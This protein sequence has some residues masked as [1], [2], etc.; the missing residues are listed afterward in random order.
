MGQ[1]NI[2]FRPGSLD[3]LIGYTEDEI[4]NI[5]EAV[6]EATTVLI[7]GE[8]GTRKCVTG[9]TLVVTNRGLLPIGE[10]IDT[11]GYTKYKGSLHVR[12]HTGEWEKPSHVLKEKSR[13][14][15]VET[16]RGNTIKAT[17]EHP[18]LV[19]NSNGDIGWVAV[20]SI[21]VGGFLALGKGLDSDIE[22]YVEIDNS[23]IRKVMDFNSVEYKLPDVVTE[24]VATILGLLV[25]EGSLANGGKNYVA[26]TNTDKNLLKLFKRILHAWDS[27]FKFDTRISHNGCPTVRVNSSHLKQYLESAGLIFQHCRHVEIPRAI[28]CS[29]KTVQR[30]FLRAYFEGDG[31]LTVQDGIETITAMN[32]F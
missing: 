16:D 11:I 13:V 14:I 20:D 32:V 8:T 5:S 24:D 23:I 19:V 22:D 10:C 25:S 21:K 12:T 28:M 15:L 6:A 3:K 27:E 17:P 1:Y 7:Y 9:D 4:N 31:G 26:F 2:D 30:A 29:P 18:L